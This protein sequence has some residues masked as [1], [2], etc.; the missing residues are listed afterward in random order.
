MAAGYAAVLQPVESADVDEAPEGLQL[1]PSCADAGEPQGLRQVF[2][3]V[4]AG[5]RRT[6]HHREPAARAERGVRRPEI[7]ERPMGFRS[8]QGVHPRLSRSRVRRSRD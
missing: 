7:P 1:R 2:C 5:L 6:R 3:Q 4:C 8:A